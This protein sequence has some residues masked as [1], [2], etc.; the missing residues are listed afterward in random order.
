MKVVMPE[1]MKKLDKIAVQ[2]YGIPSIVL[3]ENAGKAVADVAERA[4]F[5]QRLKAKRVYVFCGKGN[6]GGDGFAAARHLKNKGFEVEVFAV[7]GKSKIS[8]D[9]LINCNIIEKMGIPTY[10]I[11]DDEGLKRARDAA[12]D[13]AFIIDALLGTG[14][15]GEVKGILKEVINIINNSTSYKIA[16]DIPSGVCGATGKILGCVVKADETVTMGLLKPGLLL[17]PGALYTGKVTVADIG[18]PVDL[19]E[20][21]ESEGVLLKEDIIKSYFEPYPPNVHKGYFGKVFIIAG[22]KGLTGAAALC[23]LASQRAGAGLVTVGVPESLTPIFEIKLTEVMKKPLPDIDGKISFK[24]LEPALEFAEKVDAVAIGP[25]LSQDEETKEFVKQFVK[26]CNKPMVIDAD[27]LN[28]FQEEPE[29]L[30]ERGGD[31]VLTPHSGELSRLLSVSVAEI[32]EDRWQAVTKAAKKFNCTVLLKGARTLI[33]DSNSPVYINPTGN[34]GMA[35]GGSGDVLTGII[36][37]FLARKM[38]PLNAAQAGAYIHGL[39]GDIAKRVKG[40]ISLIA[41]DIIENLDKAF[42]DIF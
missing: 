5:E 12:K 3:M 28:A 21:I 14:V 34:P 9:A 1:T 2:E 42:L 40:E 18:M 26:N 29:R 37:A 32:E 25:G 4:F 33:K 13:D 20:K 22:S 31:V 7:E 39:A 38:T 17:Y 11:N 35:T 24:A 10:L 30:L 6:N 36:A 15:K 8:G 27:G 41:G 23:G 19:I 16:V